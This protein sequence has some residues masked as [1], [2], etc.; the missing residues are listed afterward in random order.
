MVILEIDRGY[1]VTLSLRTRTSTR[2][3]FLTRMI[4]SLLRVN[5]HTDAPRRGGYPTLF[6]C[7]F[8]NT[9]SFRRVEKE[10][11]V[12]RRPWSACSDLNNLLAVI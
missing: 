2:T 7:L 3:E 5:A 1:L 11:A 4:K 8:S 12:Q 6:E 9:H 10:E